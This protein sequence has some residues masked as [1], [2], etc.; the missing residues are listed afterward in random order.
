[1]RSKVVMP[2]VRTYIR[3]HTAAVWAVMLG[4]GL[5]LGACDKDKST[6][7]PESGDNL[8]G[9]MASSSEDEGEPM[10]YD[11]G[12]GFVDEDAEA[13]SE[14][15]DGEEVA[16]APARKLPKRAEP[17]Q[18]CKGKGKN[19]VCEMVDPKPGVS[20]AH[21]VVALMGDFRW[22]MSPPQVFKVLSKGIED[23]YAKRQERAKDAMTQD[24]NRRWRQEQINLIKANHVKF[25]KGSKHRWGVSLVKYEYE[26]DA[27]EEMLWIKESNGMRKFYFFKD[28]E[29]WKIFYAYNTEIW[30]GMS[31]AQVVEEKFKK[32]F[33]MSP[34]AK[35]KQDPKTKEP[36]LRYYEWTSM[37]GEKIRSFDMT[38]VHGV[39]A[40]AVVDGKAEDRI[41][42]RLPN[43]PQE[44]QYTDVVENVLGGT[45]VCYNKDGDIVECSEKEALG[46]E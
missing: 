2:R 12:L 23:E 14:L 36:L 18:K 8:L 24:A 10:A 43:L 16:A 45:D 20:A 44:T 22:G 34:Q 31:Y 27:N 1:M 26:D 25:T 11:E 21:G 29:L 30:P 46:L 28:G 7:D 35:V 33:G 3:T 5:G 13:G 32:W 37:D 41:G 4:L 39:I 42:E 38:S 15:E 19:R 9:P 17:V 6:V 40:L